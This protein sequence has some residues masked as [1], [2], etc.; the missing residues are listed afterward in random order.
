MER[1]ILMAKIT[2]NQFYKG[3]SLTP[4]VSNGAFYKS[5]NLDIHGQE[6]L[7]RINYKPTGI[8]SSENLMRTAFGLSQT[9]KVYLSEVISDSTT[10]C[11]KYIDMSAMTIGDLG[12]TKRYLDS[13]TYWKG[14]L[15]GTPSSVRYAVTSDAADLQLNYNKIGLGVDQTWGS[16]GSFLYGNGFTYYKIGHSLR[17]DKLYYTNAFYVG[18]LEENTGETFLPTNADT[19]TNTPTHLEH[20]N[21]VTCEGFEDF[22]RFLATFSNDPDKNRTLIFLWDTEAPSVEG[23]FVIEEP[24]MSRTIAREGEIYISGGKR[25]NIYRLT[26]SG[27]RH[28]A[29]IKLGDYDDQNY[30]GKDI[31]FNS[32]AWWKDRLMVGIDVKDSCNLTPAG[33][34]SIKDGVVN[35][36]FIPSNGLTDDTLELG[37]MITYKDYLLYGAGNGTTN[38]VDYV[39]DDANRLSSG[40]Y[41][42]TGLLR[43]GYK[44]QKNFIDRIEMI[45]ARPLQTGE[46]FTVSYRRNINDSYTTLATKSY[47]TD[48]AQSSFVLPGIKNIENI[49]LKIELGTGATSKNTPL[50]QEITLF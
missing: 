50:L 43:A 17:N 22:G 42:E 46:S 47:T 20:P 27:L 25:G 3:Q 14:Y 34:Y 36:E 8:T 10:G 28:Y 24:H 35:H 13:I 49:Q 1:Y 26:E 31:V 5:A 41:L 18:Q 21:F 19:Y 29:Q 44:M 7:A 33:I 39:R 16:F 30:I 38:V 11:V 40:C 4:Y 23:Q 37:G 32:M 2:I 15:I 12:A 9:D 6:G 45:L 48:G